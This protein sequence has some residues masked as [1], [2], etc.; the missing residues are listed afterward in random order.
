MRYLLPFIFAWALANTAL[1]QTVKHVVVLGIDGLSVPG[2]VRAK[3]PN[4]D[5]LLANGSHTLNAK[6]VFPTV[7]S[8]S[9]SSII[10]GAPPS[11]HQVWSNDWKRT[12]LAGKTYCG[13]AVGEQFPTIFKVLR[14]QY[15]QADIATFYHWDGFGRLLEDSVCTT[16]QTCKDETETAVRA[17]AYIR[18]RKPLFTFLQLDHVD[19]AGHEYKWDSELYVASV[20]KTDS[21]V[22][23]VMEAVRQAGLERETVFLFVSDHGGIEKKHGGTTPAEVDVPWL[24]AGA[25]IRRGH[26]LTGAVDSYD[27]ASTVAYLLG[28]PVPT[29]WTGRVITEAL[30]APGQSQG[31][32]KR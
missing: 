25:G 1:G 30:A 15:P 31:G 8:P 23:L 28:C 18:A 11:H 4:I 6:T 14:A 17:A 10:C 5:Q 3:K 2:F 21:L 26:V 12:E 9:W 16:K 20:N 22:G 7:S 13:Q 19:H 24:I 32:S 29:C 27:T